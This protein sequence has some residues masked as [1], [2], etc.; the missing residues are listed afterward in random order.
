MQF[1]SFGSGSHIGLPCWVKGKKSIFIGKNVHIWRLSRITASNAE[2][3]RRVIEIGEGCILHP[4]I[5]ISAISS[6]CIG[7]HVLIA[8]NCY[9]TD[10][11]HKWQDVDI[12][13]IKNEHVIAQK[14]RIG[15]HVWLGEKVVV[16]KGV[17]IGT[18]S[19]IG[20]S[21]VVT[22]SI[23]PFSLAVGNPAR[24]IKNYDH[25]ARKWVD[26]SIP[27]GL[28]HPKMES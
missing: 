2:P 14:T 3:G 5:H 7:D 8:A 10:H 27:P 22:K 9:I 20:S 13:P 18:N 23:P 4:S 12:P 28:H 24:V 6:V 25:D 16:L 15:D 21:S 1:G 11:D 17:T 19:I 26:V